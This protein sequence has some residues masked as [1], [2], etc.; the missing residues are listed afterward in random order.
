LP[1]IKFK[2]LAFDVSKSPDYEIKFKYYF[3]NQ[4]TDYIDHLIVLDFFNDMFL[5]KTEENK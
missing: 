4:I 5:T 3:A 2:P 1:R